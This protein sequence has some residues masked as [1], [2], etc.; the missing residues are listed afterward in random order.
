MKD[1]WKK[2]EKNKKKEK[3]V[4]K[5]TESRMKSRDKKDGRIYARRKE[6]EGDGRI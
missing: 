2:D 5:I 4:G 6:G 1:I 3:E